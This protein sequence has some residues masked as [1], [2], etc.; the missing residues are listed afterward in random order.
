MEAV[1]YSTFRRNL[2]SYMVKAKDDAEPLLITS[3]DPENNAVLVNQRDWDSMM[4]TL[5][6]Y[7][8]P[9]LAEKLTKG[10]AEIE[11]TGGTVR[12]LIDG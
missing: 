6:V 1:A 10:M 5:R 4:E 8:N 2:K 9:Y 7:N 11:A 3:A 12:E